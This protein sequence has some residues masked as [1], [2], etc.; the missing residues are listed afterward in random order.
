[1]YLLLV[2]LPLIGSLCAGFF[3]RKIGPLGA[4]YITISCLILTFLF[5]I[6]G[7]YEVSLLNCCVYVKFTSWINSEMLNVD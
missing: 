3:G 7:F 1:M 2:F 5:S 6:V 4:S